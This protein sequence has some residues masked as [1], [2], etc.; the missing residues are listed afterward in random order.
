[1]PYRIGYLPPQIVMMESQIQRTKPPTEILLRLS[2]LIFWLMLGV[3]TFSGP[4]PSEENMLF[5]L[6]QPLAMTV[7][8]GFG[9][10]FWYNTRNFAV[11][12]LCWSSMLLL[13]FQAVCGAI[14]NSD[15]LYIV[16]A[17]I[18][19]VLPGRAASLWIAVQTQLLIAWIFWL[20]QNGQGN[21]MFLQIPQLP[22]FVVVLLTDLGVFAGH[23]FA[24]FMGYLVASEA[25]GRRSAERYNAELLATQDLLAQS[26]RIAER[27][28]V[29][30]ELHDSLGHHLVALKVNLELAQ[31]LAQDPAKTA[32]RDALGIVVG[33]L[34][35]VREVVGHVRTNPKINLRQALET[36]LG[37]VTEF[38]VELV[39]P[40]ALEI[41][42]PNQAHILFRCVQEAV[43]NA[44]KYARAD[45]LHIEF[46]EDELEMTLIVADNGK[47]ATLLIPGHGLKGM[48]ERLA[49]A[50]GSLTIKH[51]QGFSL[52]IRLPRTKGLP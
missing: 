23:G 16:A 42:D 29:A 9:L 19:L 47:G 5:P 10:A 38:S 12:T 26:S 8:L 24:F 27:A 13:V 52:L 11:Q 14:I 39:F 7:Y 35:D 30:R 2:I 28:Y 20:D 46:A 49:L 33:L 48:Q 17:E 37:G 6:A 21:L 15:L 31:Q 36:L 50:G 40:D 43:T 41:S 34:R 22:H 44:I 4:V 45:K 32:V 18:P 3:E 25:R 51:D 1:M